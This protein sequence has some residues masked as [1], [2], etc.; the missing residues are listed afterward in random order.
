MRHLINRKVIFQNEEVLF[1]SQKKKK[2]SERSLLPLEFSKQRSL[3]GGP[4]G[5]FMAVRLFVTSTQTTELSNQNRFSLQFIF[6]LWLL[7]KSITHQI[8]CLANAIF[9]SE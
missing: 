5:Y 1:S 2:K 4:Q 3:P 6:P 8:G 7:Y 9:H